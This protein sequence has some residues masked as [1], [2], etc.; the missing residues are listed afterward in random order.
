MGL[1]T[2]GPGKLAST[3]DIS[4]KSS[5]HGSCS[6]EIAGDPMRQRISTAVDE[7]S[8]CSL[9]ANIIKFNV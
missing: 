6:D 7:R 2:V 8:S 3:K 9:E 5:M 1:S 4:K